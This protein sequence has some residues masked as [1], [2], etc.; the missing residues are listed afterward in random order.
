MDEEQ[1]IQAV[2]RVK[3]AGAETT[4]AVHEALV[5]EGISVE[6]SQVK[7][8]ASKATK[9]AAKADAASEA[10][11]PA[12][13]AATE[14]ATSSKKQAKQEKQKAEELKA[15]QAAMME[16]QRKLRAIKSGGVEQAVTITGTAEDFV[17][18]CTAKALA[19]VLEEGDDKHLKE[20]IEADIAALDWVRLAS[21]SGALSLTEDVVALGGEMQLARLKEARGA[22]DWAAARACFVD[23][24]GKRPGD[25]DYSAVDRMV[26]RS[27]AHQPSATGTEDQMAEM[28]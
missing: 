1:L 27:A 9:R 5:A 4:A 23:D 25:G 16:A 20:R 7:K 18:R 14:S 11:K 21:A 22:K 12:A 17:Q 6:L 28:D 3:L 10:S 2:M 13:P 24:Q 15:A 8:A 19:G 26:A